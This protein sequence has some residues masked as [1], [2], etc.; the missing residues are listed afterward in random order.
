MLRDK[1]I[2]LAV[3]ADSSVI[4]GDPK[5]FNKGAGAMFEK[6]QLVGGYWELAALPNRIKLDSIITKVLSIRIIC[7][8]ALLLLLAFL[9]M[10]MTQ[11]GKLRAMVRERTTSLVMA[12]QQLEA[13][14]EELIATEEELREQYDLL[15]VSEKQLRHLAYHDTVTGLHNRVYFQERLNDM[16]VH[17]KSK[18]RPFALLFIDLDHFKMI[19][20]TL[21]HAIGDLLLHKVGHRLSSILTSGEVFSQPQVSGLPSVRITAKMQLCSSRMQMPLCIRPK[22]KERTIS[23][24]MIAR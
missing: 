7:S 22:K 13:T 8:F 12:N 9:Y 6:V 4:L 11:K 5:L 18:N 24:Y 14:Y 17:A 23:A 21:G 16:L 1:G 20:D 3:R 15:E 19:N 2:D 10:Q